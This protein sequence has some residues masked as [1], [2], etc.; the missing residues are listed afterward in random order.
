L[1][2]PKEVAKANAKEPPQPAQPARPTTPAE[3]ADYEKKMDAYDK[4]M[5]AW[6]TDYGNW[7]SDREGAIQ[8]AEAQI[9]RIYDDYKSTLN[10]NL[11]SHWG[12]QILIMLIM[13][14]VLV[15]AQKRKD[16]V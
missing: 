4:A 9:K 11:L 2:K 16:I 5:K 1:R 8:G 3:Q 10:V 15:V 12:K 13:L 6:Q 14:A 7:R